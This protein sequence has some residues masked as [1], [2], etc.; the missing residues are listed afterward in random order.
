MVNRIGPELLIN[1][2]PENTGNRNRYS[3]RNQEEL[4]TPKCNTESYYK[5]FIPQ[6]VKEWNNLENDKKAIISLENFK[7][8]VKPKLTKSKMYYNG[9]NRKGEIFHTRL[10]AKNEDLNQNLY[11]RNLV[12]SN[13]C[14]CGNEVEDI[15]HYLIRCNLY[16]EKRKLL[17]TTL[18]EKLGIKEAQI[19]PTLLLHGAQTK[20]EEENRLIIKETIHFILSTRRFK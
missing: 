14:V 9:E 13:E 11:N 5:S 1:L 10:R 19:T 8:A 2:L 4:D 6:A 18:E 7:K 3:L 12:P 17:F 15:S 20:N 16:S